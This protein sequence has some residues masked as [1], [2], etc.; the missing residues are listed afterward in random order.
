[1]LVVAEVINPQPHPLLALEPGL[2]GQQE[3]VEVVLPCMAYEHG[4]RP[5]LVGGDRR[6]SCGLLFQPLAVGAARPSATVAFRNALHKGEHVRGGAVRLHL[7]IH[8]F[9]EEGADGLDRDAVGKRH[10]LSTTLVELN[11]L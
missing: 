7:S 1:M 10:G 8:V 5:D 6:G 3:C 9:I 4:G 2:K 11:W